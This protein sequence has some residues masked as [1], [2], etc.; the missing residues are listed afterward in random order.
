M[1]PRHVSTASRGSAQFA[2]VEALVAAHLRRTDEHAAAVVGP[3]VVRAHEP[4]YGPAATLRDDHAAVPAH[5]R[6]RDDLI[7]CSA[8]DQERL[9]GDAQ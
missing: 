1:N 9:A 3:A 7:G 8:H 2:A 4:R 5:G 6:H